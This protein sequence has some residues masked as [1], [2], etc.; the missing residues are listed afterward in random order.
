MHVKY[1]CIFLYLVK[2]TWIVLNIIF[3]FKFFKLKFVLIYVRAENQTIRMKVLREKYLRNYLNN[4]FL[5]VRNNLLELQKDFIELND[6]ELK[7]REIKIKTE[8]QKLFFLL[9]L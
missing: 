1:S 6:I 8:I 2:I 5:K 7:D 4:Q 3:S 9:F